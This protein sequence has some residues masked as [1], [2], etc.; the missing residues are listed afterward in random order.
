MVWFTDD[1]DKRLWQVDLNN[2]PIARPQVKNAEQVGVY[3]DALAG[4]MR[5]HARDG[6]PVAAHDAAS[7]LGVSVAQLQ[8]WLD[9][10]NDVLRHEYEGTD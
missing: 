5:D 10:N 3:Y 2:Q 7:R 6:Q 1:I 4:T 9:A 8:A